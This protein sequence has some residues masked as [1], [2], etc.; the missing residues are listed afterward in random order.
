MPNTD[1][2]RQVSISCPAG[3]R[4]DCSRQVSISC[5]AG[6]RTDWCSMQNACAP[7]SS[8]SVPEPVRTAPSKKGSVVLTV[9]DTAC[10]DD[11][12]GS[13]LES[14]NLAK[15]KQPSASDIEELLEGLEV[16]ARQP[17]KLQRCNAT[18]DGSGSGVYSLVDFLSKELAS[19]G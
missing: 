14:I 4:T 13:R 10:S 1:G 7:G 19:A 8:P 3:N 2:V 5:P 18:M 15:R 12:A 16:Q 11:S 17:P 9:D 6:S